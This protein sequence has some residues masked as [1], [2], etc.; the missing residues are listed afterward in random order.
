[1]IL[2]KSSPIQ[3]SCWPCRCL[4]IAFAHPERQLN[5]LY[6]PLWIPLSPVKNE[7]DQYAQTNIEQETLRTSKRK[8]TWIS[9]LWSPAS[10]NVEQSSNQTY[11]SKAP[12]KSITGTPQNQLVWGQIITKDLMIMVYA[13]THPLTFFSFIKVGLRY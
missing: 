10:L 4:P 7:K 13:S 3:L 5:V 9:H 6:I 12:E 11:C 1:M 2:W 8:E